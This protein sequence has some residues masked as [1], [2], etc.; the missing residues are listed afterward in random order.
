MTTDKTIGTT[1]PNRLTG[2]FT[3]IG[4]VI[5]LIGA[6]L[7]GSSGTDL[8]AALQTG[9]IVGYLTAASGV[10]GL[11][12]ANLSCWITGVF[13]M[14]TALHLIADLIKDRPVAA[15]ATRMCVNTAVPLAI[16]SFITMLVLVVQLAPGDSGS[17]IEIAG[18]IGWIGARADDLATALI[19]GAAP[20]LL[21]VAG[22]GNWAP[23]WLMYWGYL[24]GSAG[25]LSIVA[26][27]VPAISSLGFIIV[28]VGIGWMI[29]AGIVLRKK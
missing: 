25:L 23:N 10:K 4:A 14:G 26:I 17:S 24:A 9:D 13:L 16:T 1:A 28:P 8:W 21:S 12:I 15:R 11:L 3:I 19:I 27:Y 20:L 6:A 29:A 22:K 18:A 5:M 7:W 2:N